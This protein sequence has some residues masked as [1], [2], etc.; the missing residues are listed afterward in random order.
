LYLARRGNVIRLAGDACRFLITQRRIPMWNL[1]SRLIVAGRRTAVP[2]EPACLPWLNGDFEQRVRLRERWRAS[3][4][5]PRAVHP[6][7][8]K[9]YAS[10]SSPLWPQLFEGLDAERTRAAF[11]VRHPFVDLRLLRFMLTV[12]AVPW[13][14][15]KYLLRRAMRG[16]LPATVLQRTKK[17]VPALRLW[18]NERSLAAAPFVPVP[19]LSEYIDSRGL[20]GADEGGPPMIEASIRVRALNHWLRNIG[21]K[22]TALERGRQ[23][24][25]RSSAGR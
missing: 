7:R 19:A 4:P 20:R 15:R 18:D 25:H 5:P 12:P 2:A 6:V 23:H 9:S 3:S 10:L 8:P 17:S 13:C 24:E 21:M 16:D 14:R 22:P 11:E 1:P